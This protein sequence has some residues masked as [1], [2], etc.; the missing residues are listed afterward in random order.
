MS[1]RVVSGRRLL[2]RQTCAAVDVAVID[3][4][5]RARATSPFCVSACLSP[6]S[7][8]YTHTH[9][10]THT[11]ACII[12]SR[13]KKERAHTHSELL[14]ALLILLG[15]LFVAPFAFIALT[16]TTLS[17]RSPS[18]DDSA[19]AQTACWPSLTPNC[20]HCLQL[21]CTC[22]HSTH[23]LLTYS[24]SPILRLFLEVFVVAFC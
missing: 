22:R 13:A 8:T 19:S 1:C 17:S 21:Q 5:S 23:A 20:L 2:Q 15:I 12:T 11:L 4:L 9:I 24:L 18:A 6:L 16:P 14:H 3:L 10:Q 7:T